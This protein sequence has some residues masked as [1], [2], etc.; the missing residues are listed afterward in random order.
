MDL[1]VLILDYIFTERAGVIVFLATTIYFVF[2]QNRKRKTK[3]A[4]V[5]QRDFATT[6]PS[7]PVLLVRHRVPHGHGGADAHPLWAAPHPG[8]PTTYTYQQQIVPG[9]YNTAWYG[10]QNGS[11]TLA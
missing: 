10:N 4:P 8:A 2:Q 11:V 5:Q 6:P 7:Q 9:P 1:K 3:T